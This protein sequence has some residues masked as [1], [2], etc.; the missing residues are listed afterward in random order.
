VIRLKDLG[1]KMEKCSHCAGC[2]A[3]CP[4]YLETLSEPMVARNRVEVIRETLYKKSIPVS[5]R[6]REIINCCLLCTNCT[7]NCA[8]GV[9]IDEII[10]AARNTLREK[11][12]VDLK[13][14]VMGK[15]LS[16]R[17]LT[18]LLSKAGSMAQKVGI[19][20]RDV[21]KLAS[22]TFDKYYQGTVPA[23]GETRARVAYFVGCGTNFM[24]PDTGIAT[25]KVLTCNGVEVVIPE[26]QVCCGIP[27]MAEGDLETTI[28]MIRTNIEIFADMDVDAIVTDCTS[29]GMMFKEKFQKILPVD[30]PLQ[31]KAEKVA[32]RI[33]EATD[34]LNQLGLVKPPGN[35]DKAFTYHV[36]CHRGWNTTV[37]NAPR[38]LLN[39]VPGTELREMDDPELCCGAGGIFYLEH[40]ELSNNI[41]NRRIEE[42]EATG[43]ETV[44]TQCPVCRFYL[45]AGLKEKSVEV[46]HPLIM[47]ARAYGF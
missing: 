10:I 27:P 5:S 39:Q 15:M 13:T 21:P 11:G 47:L 41:R 14:A 26:G 2:E 36:P 29:C 23:E 40:G 25:V 31:E 8:A 9:P 37:R 28:S 46:V 7:Q 18:G 16:Q 22:K 44:V 42:V 6:A 38:E 20:T 34:Y 33:I 3:V 19:A 12:G 4:V 1:T 24:W 45:G 43:V 30:D 17:K 32:S 35:L